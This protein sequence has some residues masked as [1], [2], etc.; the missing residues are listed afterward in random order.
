MK[1]SLRLTVAALALLPGLLAGQSLLGTQ[2]LGFPLEPLDARARG[3][4]S[5]GTGLRGTYLLPGD[6]AAAAGMLF[7]TLEMTFQPEWGNGT[8][9]DEEVSTT[10]T[11]FPLFVL[12]YPLARVGGTVTLTIGSFM[13]QRWVMRREGTADLEGTATPITDEFRS[14]GGVSVIR[15]GWA[16]GVG[17]KLALAAG[18]GTYAGSVARVFTR[19]FDSL[20]VSAGVP[21]F[22]EGG[23]WGYGGVSASFGARWDPVEFLRVSGALTWSSDLDADPSKG[24]AGEGA[25][26]DLP[27]ELRLGA[28]GV[29]TPELDLTL[30]LTWAD[31]KGSADGLE[32]EAVAGAVWSLGGGLEW[33]GLNRGS[34]SFPLRV[35]MRRSTLPF[36]FGDAAPRESLLA[37]G[38]GLDLFRVEEVV[39]GGLDFG[40]ERGRREAGAFSE[41]FWRGTVTVKV[42]GF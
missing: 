5:V 21:P 17:D 15:L 6:P 37:A 2:G 39:V 24:T 38:I 4:G 34:R 28:S 40:V 22:Q 27:L 23:E 1:R 3:L 31:W 11:R 9:G 42:A 35:G 26:F 8:V 13:D 25:A 41:E 10:G 18:V 36:R 16:Q 19:T 12:G 29:L 33:R 20:A 30:G 14:D 7:P 32:A